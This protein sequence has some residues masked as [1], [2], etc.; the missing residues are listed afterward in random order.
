MTLAEIAKEKVEGQRIILENNGK[1]RF[2]VGADRTSA[3]RFG[4]LEVVDTYDEK[5]LLAY[6]LVCN[7]REGTWMPHLKNNI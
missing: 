2:N 5:Y 4:V 6:S 3:T 7:E 1:V